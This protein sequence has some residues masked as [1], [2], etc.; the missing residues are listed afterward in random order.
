MATKNSDVTS[1]K[2][3]SGVV[4]KPTMAKTHAARTDGLF[5]AMPH[6]HTALV[7]RIEES[8]EPTSS[9]RGE[10]GIRTNRPTTNPGA[11]LS[12]AK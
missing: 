6:Y 4:T 9:F 7:Q 5:L 2:S 3:N 10:W 8:G 11:A 12:F 1:K